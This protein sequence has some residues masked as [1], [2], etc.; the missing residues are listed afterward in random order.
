MG[1]YD[2]L[3]DRSIG[4]VPL[5]FYNSTNYYIRDNSNK[6]SRI[7]Y[8]LVLVFRLVYIV[9]LMIT[10]IVDVYMTGLINVHLL[11]YLRRCLNYGQE[12]VRSERTV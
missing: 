5:Y 9:H 6:V 7:Y 11:Y 8:L 12:K 3:I 1:P 2:C 4:D 10:R